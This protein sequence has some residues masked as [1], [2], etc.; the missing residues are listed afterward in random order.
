MRRRKV[1]MALCCLV[2][3]ASKSHFAG[4]EGCHRLT[5]NEFVEITRP[6]SQPNDLDYQSPV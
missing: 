4:C 3:G 5:P 1:E 6:G 2:E